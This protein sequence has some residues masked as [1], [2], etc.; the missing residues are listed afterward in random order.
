MAIEYENT[1]VEWQNQGTEPSEDLKING[2]QAGYKPPAQVFNYLQN[3]ISSCLNELQTKLN[4][5]SNAVNEL[6]GDI[7]D[8]GE[9]VEQMQTDI[10]NINSSIDQIQTDLTTLD[11]DAI[12]GIKGNGTTINPSSTGIVNITP[13]NIGA[14]ASTH[15]H[16][17]SQI[18]SGTLPIERGGTGGATAE[19]VR[20]NLGVVAT[21]LSNVD[22]EVFADKAT[23]AGVGSRTILFESETAE[24]ETLI[25]D[26]SSPYIT[27]ANAPVKLY[28]SD[29]NIEDYERIEIWGISGSAQNDSDRTKDLQFIVSLSPRHIISTRSVLISGTYYQMTHSRLRIPIYNDISTHVDFL[30]YELSSDPTA[31]DNLT[32][33]WAVLP[34]NNTIFIC[35]VIGYK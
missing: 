34:A 8:V 22:N 10:T 30:K 18:T 9:T 19:E 32:G 4:E 16:N 25:E 21:D 7:G 1:P 3:N 15:Y 20:E 23:S 26:T 2:F 31:I 11:E 14:A 35:K 28:F 27:P 13:N 24:G 33:Y 12:K 17:A 29:V 6:P 5:L